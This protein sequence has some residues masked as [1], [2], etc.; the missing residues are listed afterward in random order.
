MHKTEYISA[1]IAPNDLALT[2]FEAIDDW[3]EVVK[4]GNIGETGSQVNILNY[5]TMDTTVTQKQKYHQ[6]RRS[7]D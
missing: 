7:D 4:V 2:D 3:V 1:T 5:D 6:C